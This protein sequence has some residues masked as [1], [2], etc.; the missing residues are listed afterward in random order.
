MTLE[1]ILAEIRKANKSVAE[2]ERDLSRARE[3]YVNTKIDLS[4]SGALVRAR[5]NEWYGVHDSERDKEILEKMGEAHDVNDE[6]RK[7]SYAASATFQQ[8][9]K[10]NLDIA[11]AY[12]EK[13]WKPLEEFESASRR[14]TSE[15]MELSEKRYRDR[16]ASHAE[17]GDE[18]G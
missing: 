14:K 17:P 2:A 18:F 5:E 10:K 9:A 15:L 1:K 11:E 6:N 8:E 12:L 13:A 3:A 16:L 4:E 7:T